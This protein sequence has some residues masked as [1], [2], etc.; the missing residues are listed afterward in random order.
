M[1]DQNKTTEASKT[2]LT[3]EQLEGAQGGAS[4]IKIGDIE[5]ESKL[6]IGEPVETISSLTRGK[7]L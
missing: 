4:Y 6:K 3:D 1:S 5:G 7:G 2:E